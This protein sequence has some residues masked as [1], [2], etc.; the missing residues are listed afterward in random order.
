M[1]NSQLV[2][3]AYVLGGLPSFS[4]VVFFGYEGVSWSGV[5]IVNLGGYTINLDDSWCRQQNDKGSLPPG[6]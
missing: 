5:G 2:R 1:P 6:F 3:V 4:L